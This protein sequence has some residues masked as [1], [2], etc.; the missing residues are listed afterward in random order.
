MPFQYSSTLDTIYRTPA[1]VHTGIT[2]ATLNELHISSSGLHRVDLT[3]LTASPFTKLNV[4]WWPE[5]LPDGTDA[6]LQFEVPGPI[7]TVLTYNTVVTASNSTEWWSVNTVTQTG[8]ISNG[9]VRKK[10]VSEGA[11]NTY[12]NCTKTLD[13]E[14]YMGSTSTLP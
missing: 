9:T 14:I 7:G 1:Q 11:N 2:F 13:G 8:Y 12:M 5:L 3:G 4:Y 6:Q 10:R